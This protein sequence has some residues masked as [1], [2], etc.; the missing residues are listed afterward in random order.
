M[1]TKQKLCLEIYKCVR[2]NFKRGV[3]R[4]F[5]KRKAIGHRKHMFCSVCKRK[6]LFL[7]KGGDRE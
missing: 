2:C 6:Q 7:Y 4:K 5:G 3:L 1:N